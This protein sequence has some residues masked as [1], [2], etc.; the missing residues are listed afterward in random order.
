MVNALRREP[1]YSEAK[2]NLAVISSVDGAIK[3]LSNALSDIPSELLHQINLWSAN[4]N[5]LEDDVPPFCQLATEASEKLLRGLSMVAEINQAVIDQSGAGSLS[6]KTGEVRGP[7]ARPG[8][9]WGYR[10]AITL[11]EVYFLGQRQSPGAGKDGDQAR[12]NGPFQKALVTVL[13]SEK[14]PVPSTSTINNMTTAAKRQITMAW[15]KR[16]LAKNNETRKRWSGK[17]QISLMD[18]ELHFSGKS[19]MEYA[20][21]HLIISDD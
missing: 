5:E 17:P 7:K 21:W 2:A 16:T 11:G 10:L 12:P 9:D 6:P 4:E 20:S 13:K 15:A 3:R 14:H 8:D 19:L 18:H 1:N